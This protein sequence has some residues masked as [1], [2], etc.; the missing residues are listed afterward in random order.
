MDQTEMEPRSTRSRKQAGKEP[1]DKSVRELLRD[2]ARDIP[3]LIRV[4]I[5]VIKAEI[6][7]KGSLV[8][9][10]VG[11]FFAAVLFLMMAVATGTALTVIVFDLFLPLWLAALTVTLL[12]ILIA[13]GL[14]LVGVQ[15]FKKLSPGGESTP[16]AD[17]HISVKQKKE[18][19]A[20]AEGTGEGA[21]SR[22]P[23]EPAGTKEER[24]G[25]RDESDVATEE[26]KA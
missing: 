21:S 4:E 20:A 9:Q 26:D 13:A 17:M 22:G 7:E 10:G 23:R 6:R 25:S 16:P 15:R 8:G 19:D 24:S 18:P 11:L 14:A 1:K 12:W 2:L 5:A 3:E